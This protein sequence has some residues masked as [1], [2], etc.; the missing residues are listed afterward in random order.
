MI[1]GRPCGQLYGFSSSNSSSISRSASGLLMCW[2][3]LIAALQDIDATFSIMAFGESFSFIFAKSSNISR[4][5]VF[6]VNPGKIS[7][8]SSHCIFLSAERFDFI[9]ERIDLLLYF[10]SI[11]ISSMLSVRMIGGLSVC[12]E[13]VFHA[14]FSSFSHKVLFSCAACWSMMNSLSSYSTI[15]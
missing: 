2:F 5:I 3:P 14:L 15:Q 9:A 7:R 6:C 8:N 4:N 11:S 13:N 10:S 1:V 12:D